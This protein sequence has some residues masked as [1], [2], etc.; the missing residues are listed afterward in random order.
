MDPALNEPRMLYYPL[1][2]WPLLILVGCQTLPEN[3]TPVQ[4]FD[5]ESYLGSWYEIARLDHPFERGL[6]NVTAEYTLRGD[7]GVRIV[8]RGYSTDE[9]EW[10]E[11]EGR[12]YFA[13]SE[14]EGF[15]RITFFRPF[16]SSY[17]IFELDQENYKYA[18]ISGSDTSSLWLL[19]RTPEVDEEVIRY[20]MEKSRKLGFDTDELIFVDHSEPGN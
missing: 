14:A 19:A 2:V 5:L 15:L 8:N 18:F 1:Y 7:G 10:R 6:R 17:I 20:F 11:V 13:G 9:G 4:D 12:G 16:Y 3:V